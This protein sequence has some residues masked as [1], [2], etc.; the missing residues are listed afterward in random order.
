MLKSI[1]LKNYKCFKDHTIDF[2]P[3]TIV[4]GR[5]NAGKST[6]VE[7]LRLISLVANRAEHLKYCS[8]PE[9]TEQFKH[10]RGV[11]PSIEELDIDF[12]C[13]F[14]RYGEP[15]ATIHATFHNGSSVQLFL[16]LENK[17]GRVHGVIRN[18]KGRVARTA[19]EASLAGIPSIAIL[20]QVGP[21]AKH[22]TILTSEHVRRNLSTS[23]A[24]RHF[25]NQIN[26][27]RQYYK[28]FRQISEETWPGLRINDFVGA[29]PMSKDPLQLL[30]QNEDF[31]AEVSWMGHGLQMWLQ[32]M[33]FLG[34][35]LSN[36]AI[37]ANGA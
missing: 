5:N 36:H 20:P 3:S 30:V 18:S 4:V 9:W 1:Q 17:K 27:L 32:T 11:Q 12:D 23:L 7:A 10:S 28:D 33:W 13:V 16:G 29:D 15:P 2:R 19:S 24:P 8:P 26:L 34:A 6:I 14:H 22:E 31:V 35:C 37:Q 21:V 25:R